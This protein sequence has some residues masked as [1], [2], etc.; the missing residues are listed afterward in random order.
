[1]PLDIYTQTES[2]MTR[3]DYQ[4]IIA[5]NGL[6]QR[7]NSVLRQWNVYDH[8]DFIENLY[9]I[10]HDA[11]IVM[12][13]YGHGPVKTLFLGSTAENVQSAFPNSLLL[14]GPELKRNY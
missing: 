8:G 10:S 5:D 9:D 7:I 6:E 2:G 14:T 4:K 11:L 1:M 3:A 12:G 13:I